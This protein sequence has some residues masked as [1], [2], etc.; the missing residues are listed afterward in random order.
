MTVKTKTF[1]NEF[2]SE[3]TI[4]V[5][6]F[7]SKNLVFEKGFLP[8]LLSLKHFSIKSDKKKDTFSTSHISFDLKFF[9]IK[10]G[11]LSC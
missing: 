1:E 11:T 5:F 10:I 6:Q 4:E 2:A 7:L 9:S 3:V 8:L